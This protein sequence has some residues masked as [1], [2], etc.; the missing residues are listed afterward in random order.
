MGHKITIYL[1]DNALKILDNLVQEIPKT[2][3]FSANRSSAVADLLRQ[4]GDAYLAQ[5]Q[6][7]KEAISRNLNPVDL[8]GRLGD[9]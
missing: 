2:L 9:E 3:G 6:A 8:G 1:N 4:Q 7:V 5:L